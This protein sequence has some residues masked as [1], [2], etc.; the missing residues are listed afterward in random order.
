MPDAVIT[1]GVCRGHLDWIDDNEKVS[2]AG[3]DPERRREYEALRPRVP[4]RLP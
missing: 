1:I 3:R 2:L 4:A